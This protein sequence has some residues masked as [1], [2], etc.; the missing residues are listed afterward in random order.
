MSRLD[1][2]TNTAHCLSKARRMRPM[3]RPVLYHTFESYGEYKGGSIG[4]R[5]NGVLI[6]NATG[7]ALGFA[8][9]NLQERGRLFIEHATEVYE[10]RVS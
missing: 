3:L 6:A 4:Q 7:K 10:G 9:F 8:L 5:Q 2:S 1:I